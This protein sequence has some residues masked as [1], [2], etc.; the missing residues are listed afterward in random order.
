M[1]RLGPVMLIVLV[2]ASPSAAQDRVLGLL[3]LPEVFSTGPCVP[4]EPRPVP[5]F[6][7]REGTKPIGSIE[8]DQNWS[9]APHG[10]CE[11]LEVRVHKGAAR[12]E[13][14]ARE[15]DYE[16]PAAVVLDQHGLWF[17]IRLEDGAA[18][19]AASRAERFL[20]LAALYDEFVGVTFINEGFAGALAAAPVGTVAGASGPRVT[21]GQSARVIETRRL[22]ERTWV[23]VEVFSHSMCEA[24]DKG[25]PESLGEGWLPA[26]QASGEPTIWFS[27][28]G[29]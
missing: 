4:F 24:A 8:V 21:A 20:P 22:A 1:T 23:H 15:Y 10:G 17:K 2:F 29:C 11:G 7:E 26:H 19:V 5:I 12:A 14:P 28:R 16:A 25:P 18:W 27:S 9:F 13:L 3:Q 6:A